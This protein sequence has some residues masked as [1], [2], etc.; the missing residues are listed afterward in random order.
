MMKRLIVLVCALLLS[1]CSSTAIHPAAPPAAQLFSDSSFAAASADV[2]ADQILAATPAMKRY[3][4]E[5][6]RSQRDKPPHRALFDALYRRDQLKIEY[7]SATT[8]TAAQTFEARSGNCISL[9][10][11]TAALA[12]EMG[13]QVQ[14]QSV[15]VDESWSRSG[16]LYISSGHVNIVLGRNKMFQTGYDASA[17]LVIDFLPPADIRSL[18]ARPIDEKTVLAMFM[19]NRAAESLVEG[20]LDN[21]Y[22]WARGAILQDP[23]F[24]SA[25]N[26]LGVIYKQHGDLAMAERTMRYMAQLTPSSTVPLY[27]LARILDSMGRDAE[28]KTVRE[29][30][31]RMEPNPPFHYFNLGLKAMEE[32]QYFK[33]R[34]LFAR[35]VERQPGYHEFHFWLALAAY[36]LGDLRL[37]DKH[38]KLALENSTT[39]R[40]H[41]LYAGKL[42][43]L[44]AEGIRLRGGRGSDPD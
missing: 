40:D 19:N 27:N 24:Y 25:Y 39:R 5:A 43:R 21:A 41:E 37:A 2:G 42:E 14:F 36:K 32:G 31:A 9:V 28:A 11:M 18:D 38:L 15:Y 20:K 8:R 1:A 22:W 7:D 35:E 23:D 33:A 4:D 29:Q 3:V 34:A 30:L 17:Y 16:S 13:L 44:R 26:T 6:L 12:R 10:I